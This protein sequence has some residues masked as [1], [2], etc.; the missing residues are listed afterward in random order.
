MGMDQQV[1]FAADRAPSWPA[2]RDL[3]TSRGL[4]PQLRMIDG[5]LA[6]PD[7]QPAPGWQ[8]LRIGTVSGM[9]TLRRETDGIRLVIWGNADSAARQ[10]WN[11]LTWV[12]AKLSDGMVEGR[13]ADEFAR[14]VDMPAGF[15]DSVNS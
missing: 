12:V 11:A 6:F 7:E 10:A 14:T 4:T 1:C 2:L 13:S 9:V 8:E 5:Q 15:I 3:L